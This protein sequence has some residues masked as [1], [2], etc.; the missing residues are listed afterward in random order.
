ML[1][2]IKLSIYHTYFKLAKLCT[3]LFSGLQLGISPLFGLPADR[4][5][6]I[7]YNEFT[8]SITFFRND[9]KIYDFSLQEAGVHWNS[10]L[11]DDK[12][13][14]LRLA[15]AS[16]AISSTIFTF[17][18][19]NRFNPNHFFAFSSTDSLILTLLKADVVPLFKKGVVPFIDRDLDVRFYI[20]RD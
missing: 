17:A 18:L 2:S 11:M 3:E 16:F 4:K 13:F 1:R 10:D 19:R 9:K 12:I 15:F 8:D 6:Q 14:S 20:H 7:E 5:L